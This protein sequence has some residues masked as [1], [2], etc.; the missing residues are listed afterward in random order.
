M[1]DAE[2]NAGHVKCLGVRLAGGGIGE[3]DDDGEPVIGETLVLS[4]ER[5]R[6]AVDFV[7]PAFEPGLTWMLPDRH[8]RRLSRE[9]SR[10]PGGTRVSARRPLGGRSSSACGTAAM[11]DVLRT[12]GQHVSPAIPPAVPLF[13]RA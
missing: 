13:G 2:W 7:L 1:T 11:A 10:L 4:H 12:A 3:V 8:L 5:R 9:G 6:R